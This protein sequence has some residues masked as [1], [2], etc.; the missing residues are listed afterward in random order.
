ATE[1]RLL[2]VDTRGTVTVL[3]DNAFWGGLY[4]HSIVRAPN[5]TIYLG[6][7]HGIAR[8]TRRANEYSMEWLVPNRAFLRN[9][10]SP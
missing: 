10:T 1:H 4:P 7:R 9:K 2:R 6:M 5:G 3:L 8:L